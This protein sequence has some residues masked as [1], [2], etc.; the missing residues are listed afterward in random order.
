M[1]VYL[2]LIVCTLVGSCKHVC[3]V[4]SFIE[5]FLDRANLFDH[6]VE[7]IIDCLLL[8]CVKLKSVNEKD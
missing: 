7:R 2:F 4:V 3:A 6:L 5:R 8:K 1:P